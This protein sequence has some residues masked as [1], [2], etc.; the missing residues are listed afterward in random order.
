MVAIGGMSCTLT[1]DC[2]C[3]MVWPEPVSIWH[4]PKTPCWHTPQSYMFQ[5]PWSQAAL[6]ACWWSQWQNQTRRRNLTGANKKYVI[7][8]MIFW[9]L[10][11]IK[12][13]T[14][15][16]QRWAWIQLIR[17]GWPPIQPTPDLTVD[18][19]AKSI[20]VTLWETISDLHQWPYRC[21]FVDSFRSYLRSLFS[22]SISTDR[23]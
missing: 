8:R 18:L 19:S 9:V 11:P 4:G 20:I 17:H 22:P 7:F 23:T 16:S 13:G 21:I 14:Y 1:W 10:G 6:L 5:W 2:V 12:M 15:F 3:K